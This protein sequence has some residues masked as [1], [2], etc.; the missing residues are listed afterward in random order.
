[1]GES[2]SKSKQQQ[3]TA[4]EWMDHGDGWTRLTIPDPSAILNPRLGFDTVTYDSKTR[5]E[6]FTKS[7]GCINK[8]K[9]RKFAEGKQGKVFEVTCAEKGGN[10]KYVMKV[11]HMFNGPIQIYDIIYM[12][13][14]AA[15]AGL[16]PKIIEAGI[17][18]KSTTTSQGKAY[19]VMEKIEGQKLSDVPHEMYTK[20]IPKIAT[21]FRDLHRL[22]IY[23][24]D[25]HDDN[26]MLTNDGRVMFID[27]AGG[28][29]GLW[30]G[31]PETDIGMIK[32]DYGM[33]VRD[34]TSGLSPEMAFKIIKLFDPYVKKDVEEYK[35]SLPDQESRH[36]DH[37]APYKWAG[38]R[39]VHFET[40]DRLDDEWREAHR[41][42]RKHRPQSR[43][44]PPRV[45]PPR[46]S[47]FGRGRGRKSRKVK[48]FLSL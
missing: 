9:G 48:K 7:G 29:M 28:T 24:D 2:F 21:A 18:L 41:Q 34:W 36:P 1:M 33:F 31:K 30:G 38:D 37:L 32:R 46:N 19:I 3:S 14:I 43:S 16:A 27:I 12:Q 25:A 40:I 5:R 17:H 10:K 13:Q 22:G 11:M 20:Y 39:E 23:H 26:V 42:L 45:S 35:K 44:S 47:S 8:K 15:Q 6:K 4:Y